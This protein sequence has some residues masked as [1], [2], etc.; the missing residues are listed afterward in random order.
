ME[1][2]FK[3]SR[4]QYAPAYETAADEKYADVHAFFSVFI[5]FSP[6]GLGLLTRQSLC[7]KS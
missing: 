5:T 2:T 7:A 6:K 4:H 1:G 3:S